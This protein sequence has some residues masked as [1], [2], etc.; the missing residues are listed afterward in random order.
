MVPKTEPDNPRTTKDVSLEDILYATRSPGDHPFTAREAHKSAC[1]TSSPWM[2]FS[3]SIIGSWAMKLLAG[4]LLRIF[5][6]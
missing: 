2:N 4:V 5:L 3:K 1:T 6:L